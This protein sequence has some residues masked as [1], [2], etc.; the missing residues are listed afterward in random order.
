[1]TQTKA[2]EYHQL[3]ENSNKNHINIAMVLA[4]LGIVMLFAIQPFPLNLLISVLFFSL[5]IIT[6]QSLKTSKSIALY[7]EHI[8]LGKVVN[9]YK[10]SNIKANSI[11]RIELVNEI[12]TEFRAAAAYT[13]GDVEVHSH[14]Y[15]IHMKDDEVIQFDNLYHKELQNA[16]R[17]WCRNNKVELNLNVR[18]MIKESDDYEF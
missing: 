16:L 2:K 8:S 7:K 12:K 3:K 11:A 13:G 15:Q 18:K 1:M 9:G 5:A 10:A 6:Y 17:G 4:V 14:Y